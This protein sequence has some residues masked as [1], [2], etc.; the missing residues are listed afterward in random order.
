MKKNGSQSRACGADNHLFLSL[1]PS[2]TSRKLISRPHLSAA[3]QLGPKIRGEKE[4]N[5]ASNKTEADDTEKHL[6]QRIMGFNDHSYKKSDSPN[7][8]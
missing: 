6:K 8:H 1:S 3:C 4:S 7:Q 5:R 2:Q